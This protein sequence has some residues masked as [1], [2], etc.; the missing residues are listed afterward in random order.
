LENL[1]GGDTALIDFGCIFFGPVINM[2]DNN[3]IKA[4]VFYRWDKTDSLPATTI[5]RCDN[6]VAFLFFTS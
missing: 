1:P 3:K 6:H 5:R 2:I 4:S